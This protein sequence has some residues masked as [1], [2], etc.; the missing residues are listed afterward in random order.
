M[1]ERARHGFKLLPAFGPDR[2]H[3][4]QR[5]YEEV[6]PLDQKP[7]GD[8]GNAGAQPG[9]KGPLIGRMVGVGSDHGP[10]SLL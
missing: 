3:V 10:A 5:E 2:H 7:E 6:E 8:H 9:K 1:T 4:C